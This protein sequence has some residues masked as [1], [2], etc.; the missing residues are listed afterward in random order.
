[1]EITPH[2]SSDV[3]RLRL[4]AGY[5]SRMRGAIAAGHPLTAEAGA[6]VLREGGNAVDAAVAAAFV[7]WVAESTL[8]GPGAGGFMLVHRS[9]D[10]STRVL[11]FFTAVP[12]L[13]ADG[14]EPRPMEAIDVDFSGGST[15]QFRIGGA[16]VAVPGAALGLEQ[17]QQ[18]YGTLQ[19]RE[20]FAP[21]IE[22][23]RSGVELTPGQAYLHEI[24]DLILRHTPESRAVY[25]RDGARLSV[26]D[27]LVQPDLARTLEVLRDYGAGELYGGELGRAV[28]AH[29]GRLG[30]PLTERDLA[31]YRVIRRQPVRAEFRGHSFLSNPP[32]S[33]GGA[34]IAYG[35]RILR[36]T[37]APGSAEAIDALARV[38]REQQQAR[39][40]GFDRALRRGGLLKLLEERAAVTRGTTHISV[41]DGAA[42]TVALTA[43]TGAGS[44]IVVP[45]TGIHLNNMLGEFTLP[46]TPPPGARLSSGMSPSMVVDSRGLPRL[47]VGSAGSLRLRGAVMQV[48]VNVVQHGLDVREAIERPRVH[49]DEEQQL[50]CEGGHDPAEVAKVEELGW[51]VVRWR[52][53]NLFF[54]GA[55][56]VTMG[57]GGALAAAGDPRRGGYGVVVE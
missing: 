2:V 1:M 38:M 50:H 28:A 35:L 16:S 43:S 10:Q 13:G 17:A 30:G 41:V 11:D 7:S 15:Q 54:G 21:A 51:D 32:P 26:G 27:R 55:G 8:T 44:G 22:L 34:L 23:A 49:L 18:S 33:S 5:G 6:R 12:G 42:N 46:R 19:W 14:F 37:G 24:L 3:Q 9:R 45:G 53:R 40:D 39:L 31:E 20:L 4:L 25:E 47:V 36:E 57:E 29:V 48:V 52:A 56:A